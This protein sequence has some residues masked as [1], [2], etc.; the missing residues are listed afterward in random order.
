MTEKVSALREM[1]V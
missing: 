1:A